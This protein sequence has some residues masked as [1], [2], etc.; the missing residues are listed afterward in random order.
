M[1]LTLIYA[2]SVPP[3]KSAMD[4]LYCHS[5]IEVDDRQVGVAFKERK[6]VHAEQG[7]DIVVKHERLVVGPGQRWFK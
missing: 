1:C 3:I 6:G 5:R 7:G 4:F 2:P